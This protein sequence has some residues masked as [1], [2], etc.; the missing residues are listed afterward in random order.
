[1]T[2]SVFNETP[3]ALTPEQAT[4]KRQLYE[5]MNPRQRKFVDRLGYEIWDP[6]QEPKEP[7]DLRT[8]R[9]GRTTQQL[10]RDFLRARTTTE[11]VSNA[12]SQGALDCALG[13]IN[14]DDRAL[15]ALEFA[16]WYHE[17]LEKEGLV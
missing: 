3:R 16:V 7:L 5:S 15:G 12:F 10:V 17:L 9:T 2:L 1:M 11:P 6:F 8:D 14:K 13:I 4:H